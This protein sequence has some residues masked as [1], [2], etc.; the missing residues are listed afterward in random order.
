MVLEPDAQV[1]G[2]GSCVPCLSLFGSK[3]RGTFRKAITPDLVLIER[4]SRAS[5]NNICHP[6]SSILNETA[7]SNSSVAYLPFGIEPASGSFS[8]LGVVAPP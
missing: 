3:T 5:E 8:V 4:L 1:S 2:A 7:G 6:R